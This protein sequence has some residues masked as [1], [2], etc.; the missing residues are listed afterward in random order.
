MSIDKRGMAT[1]KS[2]K[3]CGRIVSDKWKMIE[4]KIAME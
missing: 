4:A 1:C 3:K 2:R